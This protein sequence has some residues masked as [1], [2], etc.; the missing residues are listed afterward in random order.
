MSE[1][2]TLD[3]QVIQ[4][5]TE[6]VV[7]TTPAPTNVVIGQP[8]TV[9]TV[10]TSTETIQVTELGIVGPQ[11]PAGEPGT[12]GQGPIAYQLVQVSSW[13]Q[14]HTLGYLPEVRVIDEGGNV[15]GMSVSY[16]SPT[17]V[18]LLFPTPFTGEVLLS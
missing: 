12:G 14:A 7:I 11:G 5:P 6:T 10:S 9:N 15:V 2:T 8:T 16:P 13:A 4:G 17:T 18:Y 1:T 3:V